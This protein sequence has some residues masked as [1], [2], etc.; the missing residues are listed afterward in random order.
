MNIIKCCLCCQYV[1][2]TDLS[3]YSKSKKT[4]MLSFKYMYIFVLNYFY[5]MQK[6]IVI[7]INTLI[8]ETKVG[9]DLTKYRSVKKYIPQAYTRKYIYLT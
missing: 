5:Q 6:K 1:I 2:Y 4:R 8:K 3:K 7:S 9:Q